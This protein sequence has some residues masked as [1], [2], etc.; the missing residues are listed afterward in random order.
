[1]KTDKQNQGQA[2]VRSQLRVNSVTKKCK[3]WS[4]I[5]T[6]CLNG[7]DFIKMRK[8]IIVV[9]NIYCEGCKWVCHRNNFIHF[10]YAKPQKK[11]FIGE[12]IGYIFS[13]LILLV[14]YI[15]RD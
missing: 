3:G 13:K 10:H 15:Q 12:E 1:M 9:F 14:T 5:D 7:E 6:D 4:W 11:I 8:N 2:A